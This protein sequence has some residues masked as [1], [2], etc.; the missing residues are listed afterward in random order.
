MKPRAPFTPIMN[1]ITI[2]RESLRSFLSPFFLITPFYVFVNLI[3]DKREEKVYQSDKSLETRNIEEGQS[4]LSSS[5]SSELDLKHRVLTPPHIPENTSS[6]LNHMNHDK[7][8]EILMIKKE[9]KG[10]VK[11]EGKGRGSPGVVA[12]FL[13]DNS[14]QATA[15]KLLTEET[16]QNI[17][18]RC[19]FF[20]QF[21]HLYLR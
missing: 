16:R 3:M 4:F 9:K 13:N 15:S 8:D 2:M 10:I 18:Q 12:R 6:K 20:P 17:L 11:R 1:H 14:P 7:N 21:S 19:P 5:P